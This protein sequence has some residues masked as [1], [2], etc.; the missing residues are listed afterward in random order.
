MIAFFSGAN[1]SCLEQLKS[2]IETSKK[3]WA[4]CALAV[5][6]RTGTSLCW[7]FPKLPRVPCQLMN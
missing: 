7:F 2:Y 1:F 4:H 3:V 5:D 6:N